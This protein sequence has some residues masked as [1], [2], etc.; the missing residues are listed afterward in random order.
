MKEEV[1]Q[2]KD[3]EVKDVQIQLIEETQAKEEALQAIETEKT[4]KE[5]AE[6]N[7]EQL[8]ESLK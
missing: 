7:F 8:K 4:A 2:G 3:Q 1:T 5:E 6:K